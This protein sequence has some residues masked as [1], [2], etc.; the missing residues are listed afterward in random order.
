MIQLTQTRIFELIKEAVKFSATS[1]LS[2]CQQIKTFAVLY[3]LKDFN[4]DSLGMTHGDFT[5]GR[6]WTRGSVTMNEV[7]TP[8]PACA[9]IDFTGSM[10]NFFNRS[11]E[12]HKQCRIMI[13]LADV[14]KPDLIGKGSQ[15]ENRNETQIYSDTEIALEYVL[16]YLKR[17][18]AFKVD[19]VY[20]WHNE[21]Y[22]AYQKFTN[23]ITD[24]IQDSD[25][26]G[27]SELFFNTIEQLNTNIRYERWR[28]V[29]KDDLIA[30]YCEIVFPIH[31]INKYNPEFF[32][33]TK[34]VKF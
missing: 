32:T 33:D 26:V 34:A 11:C 17:V 24:Y 8:Y 29:S 15:C 19:G 6:F 23:I 16:Q 25:C 2:Y 30:T 4:K 9:A 31:Q 5:T 7:S 27:Y 20:G 1:D 18:Q 10:I 3:E 14:I 12:Y 22:L 13:M 21:D 28:H